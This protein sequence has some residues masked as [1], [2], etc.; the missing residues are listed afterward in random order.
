ML[1]IQNFVSA[2]R[3]YVFFICDIEAQNCY[4]K[5]TPHRA[6]PQYH[7]FKYTIFRFLFLL[8]KSYLIKL[9]TRVV[10]IQVTPLYFRFSNSKPICIILLY[11]GKTL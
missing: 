1:R 5:F 7:I 3:K 4:Q 9:S 8:S 6:G 11:R 10:A 2:A